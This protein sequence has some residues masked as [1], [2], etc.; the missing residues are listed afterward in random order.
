LTDISATDVGLRDVLYEAYKKGFTVK[1]DFARY[2]AEYV[3]MAASLGYI[4]TCL[5]ADNFSSEWRVTPEGLGELM[6][7]MND[8]GEPDP[9]EDD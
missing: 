2:K 5:F 4:T 6:F 1:S 3:A 7:L 9:Y 8:I